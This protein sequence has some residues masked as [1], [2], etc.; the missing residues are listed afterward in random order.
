M[1]K[2]YLISIVLTMILCRMSQAHRP[3]FSEKAATD[4]N[5]AVLITQ[6]NISQVIYREITED[7]KQVWLAF[8]AD[9]GFKLFLQ[10]GVPVLERLREFRPSILVI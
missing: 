4:P 7:T 5:T 10:I 3:V 1:G 8:D 6:P 9:K 2:N